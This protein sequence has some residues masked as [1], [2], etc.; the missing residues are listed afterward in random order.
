[1]AR[2]VVDGCDALLAGLEDMADKVPE[3][4]DAILEAEAD[5]AEPIIRQGVV[6]AGLVK[7][8]TL[9]D[10]IGRK[11]M[12]SYGVPVIRIGPQGEHHRYVPSAGKKGIVTSGNVGY[13][14]EYGVPRRGIR[15][16]QWLT[17][18]VLKAKG[19]AY[20]AADKVYDEY[21]KQHNL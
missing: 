10:S 3:L 2:I 6:V 5:A 13:V 19:P 12:T 1:M 11:K 7:T 21:M 4:R 14:H 17:N 16:R 8:G 15:A 9:R 20:D 18:A